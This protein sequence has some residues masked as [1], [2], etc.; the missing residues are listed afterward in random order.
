MPIP[1]PVLSPTSVSKSGLRHCSR[2]LWALGAAV[3]VFSWP[4]LQLGRFALSHDLYSH[5]ILV[6]FISAYFVWINRATLQLS[7]RLAVAAA[8]PW[9]VV[10]V[11]LLVWSGPGAF[12]EQYFGSADAVAITTGAFV[13][14]MVAITTLFFGGAIKPVLFP[15]A[16][17]IFLIPMP[18]AMTDYVESLLQYGSAAIAYLMFSAAGATV[19]HEGLLFHLPGI[20]LEVAPE[21]S[22]IH[23]TLALL[24]TSIVAGQLFLRTGWARTTLAVAI[25]PLALLRNGFR[26]FTLG[27]LCVHI[28]PHMIDSPI[29]HKGGPLFFALSLI[30]FAFL[31]RAL[32]KAER[33]RRSSPAVVPA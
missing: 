7:G 15:L 25:I 17:L 14:V 27:E 31:L 4:L 19:F 13:C 1:L 32:V 21:C 10:A 5:V 9:L 18:Q 3:L 6:P 11:A 33:P 29:H 20:S 16:F 24:I 2:W 22:G 30:P 26:V 12:Y 8:L 23:S 28:G